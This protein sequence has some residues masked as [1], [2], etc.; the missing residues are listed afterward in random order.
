MVTHVQANMFTIPIL[1]WMSNVQY[2]YNSTVLIFG[3]VIETAG[4][5]YVWSSESG[6]LKHVFQ[7]HTNII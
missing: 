4:V 3:S 6:F 2:P 7:D 1:V 5:N